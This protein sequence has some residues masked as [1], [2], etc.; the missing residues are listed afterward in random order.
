MQKKHVR[1]TLALIIFLSLALIGSALA[2][3]NAAGVLNFFD[4]MLPDA[5]QT[6][7]KDAYSLVR[8]DI[9]SYDFEHVTVSVREAIY[10]GEMLR[11]VVSIGLVGALSNFF[12]YNKEFPYLLLIS[13]ILAAP[14]SAGF[15]TITASMKA[16][17]CDDDEL[18]NGS[19]REGEPLGLGR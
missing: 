19:R 11:V 15:W 17:I 16:D 12:L 10:D 9:A 18:R 1:R 14:V 6:V 2:I 4:R 7:Q 8:S 3:T 13:Q 5:Y